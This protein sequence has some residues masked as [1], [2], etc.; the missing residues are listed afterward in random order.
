MNEKNISKKPRCKKLNP[1]IDVSAMVSISFLLMV[2]FMVTIELSKPNAMEL[3]LPE[4]YTGCPTCVI[5]CG[6]VSDRV[7]TLLL[8]GDNKIVRYIGNL[9]YTPESP[10]V[11]EYG[12]NGIRKELLLK[13]KQIQNKGF[14][15][16][17]RNSGAIVIIKPSKKSNFK[18]LIDILDEMSIANIPTYTIINDY[19]PEERKLL[20]SL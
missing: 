1:K 14:S 4:H 10:K 3:G 16:E 6:V 18:N 19:T 20:S 2:F 7:I 5:H 13:S 11:F 15:S 8:D 9:E 12:K 17:R